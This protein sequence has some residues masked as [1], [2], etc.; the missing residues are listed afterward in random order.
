MKEIIVDQV[1]EPANPQSKEGDRE[2][3]QQLLATLT[4][5]PRYIL[6]DF[7]VIQKDGSIHN[8]LAFIFW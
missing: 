3:Y 1:G 8:K 6:Y 2:C 7:T 5:E 4:D